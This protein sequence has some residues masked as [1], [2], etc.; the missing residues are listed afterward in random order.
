MSEDRA[1]ARSSRRRRGTPRRRAGR[2]TA[3]TIS[4]T[5]A[6][7]AGLEHVGADRRR[8]PPSG[9]RPW[10]GKRGSFVGAAAPRSGCSRS[11]VESYSM[12]PSTISTGSSAERRGD[13]ARPSRARA[14]SGCTSNASIGSNASHA[15]EPLGL[16]APAVGEPGV[17]RAADRFRA[18]DADRLGVAHEHQLHQSAQPRI[19][20]L[21][22]TIAE[23]QRV[24][25]R[26]P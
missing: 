16:L 2:D 14:A 13:A 20:A 6:G 18:V 21:A 23:P 9:P 26:R 1:R 24:A 4:S 15:G 10:R 11:D 19:R 3:A 22:S 8:T 5:H 12:S 7:D 25:G 17:G